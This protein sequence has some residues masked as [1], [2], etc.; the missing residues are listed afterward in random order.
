MSLIATRGLSFHAQRLGSRGRPPLVMLHGLLIG[1]LASWYFTAAPALAEEREILL[2]DLRGHG[3]SARVTSGYDVATMAADLDAMAATLGPGPVDLA[4]HSFG[5]LVAL[6][7]TLD[8]PERVRRLALVEAPLPPSQL[9]ELDQLT[10]RSP[11]ELVASLPEGLRAAV[12]EGGRRARRFVDSIRFLTTET[13]LLGD[14]GKEPDIADAELGRLACPVLC[15]YGDRSSCRS[16]GERLARVVPT[17]RL[18]VL[19]GGHFLHLDATASLTRELVA[20]F[21]APSDGGPAP[22]AGRHG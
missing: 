1:T 20:F 19:P 2:Y 15:V 16:V 6:R 12:A 5:A 13:T 7:F 8:H 9:R 10:G 21:D 14:L 3:R 18:V 4:G 22:A 17:A 11:D